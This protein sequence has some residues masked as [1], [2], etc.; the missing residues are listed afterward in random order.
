MKSLYESLLSDMHVDGHIHLFDK[1]KSIYDF[2]YTPL[3]K[4]VGFI[5]IEPLCIDKYKSVGSMYESFIKKYYN[6][7]KHILLL[8]GT[9]IDDIKK[10]YNK[11][12]K[13]YKGFGEIKCYDKYKGRDVGTKKISFIDEV[14]KFSESVGNLPIYI[15]IIR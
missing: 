12:P 8:S 3:P 6:K 1:D 13:I 7:N 14:C 4:L 10:V 11:Y 15:F 9:N 5:D 2:D